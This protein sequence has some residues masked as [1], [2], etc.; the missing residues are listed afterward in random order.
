MTSE[1]LWEIFE[2]DLADMCAGK[3]PLVS[4]RGRA[5]G[6]TCADLGARTPIAPAE[7]SKAF[8]QYCMGHM[9]RITLIQI[10]TNTGWDN[11]AIPF[12]IFNQVLVCF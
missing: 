2:G 1:G 8:Y 9:G 7:F 3:F 4:M 5:E 10:I 11:Y 12:F 6:L